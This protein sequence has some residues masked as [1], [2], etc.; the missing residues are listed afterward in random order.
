MKQNNSFYGLYAIVDDTIHAEFGLTNLLTELVCHSSA[1][2]IQLRMKQSTQDERRKL[3]EYAVT[4][5][6]HRPYL[7]IANDHSEL[8]TCDGVD[9]LHLGQLDVDFR[10]QR[11]NHPNKILGLSTHNVF[12]ANVATSFQADYIG[13]GS[14]FSTNT[15]SDAKP[16]GLVGLRSIVG[17]TKLPTVAIGGINLNNITDVASTGCK[18]A[19]VISG[20]IENKKCVAQ[21][22]HDKFKNKK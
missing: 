15:K 11:K 4:L 18:M 16:I 9:G 22:L 3:T 12:E 7:L 6:K 1:P 10:A 19:A 2:I 14:V 13:C 8:L 21:E 17:K 20:L 5:K